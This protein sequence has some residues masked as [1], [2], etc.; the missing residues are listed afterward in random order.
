MEMFPAERTAAVRRL[1][2][3]RLSSEIARSVAT[4]GRVAVEG[5]VVQPGPSRSG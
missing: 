1:S 5:E 3:V 2:L 4:V